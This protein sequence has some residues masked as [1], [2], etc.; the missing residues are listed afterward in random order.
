MKTKPSRYLIYFIA[1]KSV[2]S[3]VVIEEV[4]SCQEPGAGGGMEESGRNALGMCFLPITAELVTSLCR[5][6]T[7][8]QPGA[9]VQYSYTQNMGSHTLPSL[10]L[11]SGD[12]IELNLL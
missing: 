5:P 7:G 12:N 8:A 1:A 11:E 10:H 4:K 6:G 2:E 9:G 3:V